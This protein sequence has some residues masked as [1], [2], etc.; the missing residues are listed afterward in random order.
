MRLILRVFTFYIAL[1]THFFA[2]DA[3]TSAPVDG[4]G[5]AVENLNPGDVHLVEW[6][7]KHTNNDN[8]RSCFLR[9]TES[10]P[11]CD[12]L[13]GKKGEDWKR[14]ASATVF[15]KT[16]PV[17][18]AFNQQLPKPSFKHYKVPLALRSKYVVAA[19]LVTAER[20]TGSAIFRIGTGESRI[21][22]SP[23]IDVNGTRRTLDQAELVLN[24]LLNPNLRC[25]DL[26]DSDKTLLAIGFLDEMKP[27][28]L[29]F[30][31]AQVELRKLMHDEC[32]EQNPAV[33]TDNPDDCY[34][35]TVSE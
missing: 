21:I 6:M 25:E 7:L 26:S 20:P 5:D 27:Y 23:Y 18:A 22:S 2:C 17:I 12:Q 8:F 29:A 33:P 15:K 13:I 10:L 35:L 32:P 30:R 24:L 34:P 3:T 4:V 14:T 16:E 28:L 31:A 9:F 11:I 1:S 19:L